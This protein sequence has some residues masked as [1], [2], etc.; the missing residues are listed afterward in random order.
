[1]SPNFYQKSEVLYKLGI[2]F[3]KTNQ[4]NQ[5]INYF[6][7]SILTNSFTNKRKVDTLLKI[8]L[9]YEEKKDYSQAQRSYEAALS[10]NDKNYK[11]FQHL[12]WCNFQGKNIQVALEFI[13]KA[14]KREKD[15]PDSLYIRARCYLAVNNYN[16]AQENFNLA[17][18]KSPTEATYLISYAILLFHQA[19]YEEAFNTILKAQNLK[20]E[21]CEI[22]YNL[23]ILYEKCK[24]GGEAIVAYSRVLEIDPRHKEAKARF[25][26]INNPNQGMHERTHMSSLQMIH[27]AFNVPNTLLILKKYKNNDDESPPNS[28]RL[29]QEQSNFE[30]IN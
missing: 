24:Q 21:N 5:S 19:K 23:G 6:Q 22:W 7:N 29:V 15:N 27:P 10:Y 9:L 11:I 28:P 14:D 17:I 4:I 13:N 3:A 16:E 18:E 8:G 25:I 2:I 12:A 30:K 20:P 1:M 26:A